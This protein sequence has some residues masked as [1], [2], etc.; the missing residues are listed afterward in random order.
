MKI[1]SVTWLTVKIFNKVNSTVNGTDAQCFSNCPVVQS[2]A[3]VVGL[4]KKWGG[5]GDSGFLDLK[6]FLENVKIFRNC[7][8]FYGN[9]LIFF[10][11][12]VAKF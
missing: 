5:G 12:F 1:T 6:R 3:P 9:I 8:I 4:D 10:R 2:H 7:E 11:Y